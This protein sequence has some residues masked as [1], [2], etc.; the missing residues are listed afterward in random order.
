MKVEFCQSAILVNTLGLLTLLTFKNKQNSPVCACACVWERERELGREW[1]SS[2]GWRRLRSV[3][4]FHLADSV[5][6]WSGNGRVKRTRHDFLIYL[7]ICGVFWG[8]SSHHADQCLQ[9][10]KPFSSSRTR[11]PEKMSRGSSGEGKASQDRNWM[12]M[13]SIQKF[14]EAQKEKRKKKFW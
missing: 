4:C 10:N 13:T 14:I 8:G 1:E 11:H 7:F 9:V 12:E 2:R 6:H 5:A 3:R